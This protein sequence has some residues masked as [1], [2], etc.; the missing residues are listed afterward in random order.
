MGMPDCEEYTNLTIAD[1]WQHCFTFPR[2]IYVKDGV[3]CQRP[4]R[5]LEARK[6]DT[7]SAKGYLFE[8]GS[9]V[10]ET[11]IESITDNQFEIVLSEEMVLDYAGGRFR[12]YFKNQDKASVSAGRNLRYVEI[13]EVHNITILTDISSVEVFVNDGE[14]V[15]STRYY[16]E[17]YGILVQAKDAEITLARIS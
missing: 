16:P 7:V 12:M 8:M 9:P 14:Y 6:H 3:I 15:F 1:G 13:E 11:V 2:E 10:Q 4:I 5:E 17:E